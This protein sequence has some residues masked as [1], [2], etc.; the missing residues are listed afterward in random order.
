MD[1]FVL[2]DLKTDISVTR[3]A[4]LHYF[5]FT[6]KYRTLS[7]RHGFCELL[8]VDRGEI[9]VTA[10][11]YTG[12]L[13]AG[14]LIIHRPGEEHSLSTER[15]AP[16]VIIIGFE[17]ESE[18]LSPLSERPVTLSDEQAGRLAEVTAH[19]MNVFE[20]PYDVPNLKC[21]RKRGDSAFGAEQLFRNSLEC[22]LIELTR[23]A[24]A[25]ARSDTAALERYISENYRTKITLDNL[26]FLFGTN[27]TTLCR[28]FRETYGQ[29]VTRYVNGLRIRDA[30]RLLREGELSVTEIAEKL[31]FESLHYFS[32]LFSRYTG[33]SPTGYAK[34]K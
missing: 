13:R 30:K 1:D 32:R 34:R 33:V 17:C 8:Y 11:R 5:E 26:C 6:E 29:S 28:R 19:G 23:S 9:E 4:N 31:G 24:P 2:H 20:P 16:N 18:A 21:M 22:F 14:Q 12:T 3:V 25:R 7:D 10:E 27:K 15:G